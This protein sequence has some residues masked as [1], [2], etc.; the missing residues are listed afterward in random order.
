MTASAQY[1]WQASATEVKTDHPLVKQFQGCVS[2][3]GLNIE[4]PLV[5]KAPNLDAT[6]SLLRLNDV[7]RIRDGYIHTLYVSPDRK[8]M[9]IIQVGSFAGT[10]KV[11]GPLDAAM[12]CPTSP[13]KK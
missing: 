3:V 8:T 1:P 5:E 2:A 6:G 7:G 10:Q 13:D 9:Y 12:K 4:L 11:F